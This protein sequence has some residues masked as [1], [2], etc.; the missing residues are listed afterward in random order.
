[1]PPS[2]S[3]HTADFKLSITKALADQLAERLWPL[4]PIPLTEDAVDDLDPRPGV[5]LLYHE[6]HRVYVGKAQRK[7]STRLRRHW[8]KVRGRENLRPDDVTF[9]GLYVD[10]DLDAAAPEKLLIRRYKAEGGSDG[11][12]WNLNGFGNNDPG[13][14]RD[15]SAVPVNHFDARYPAD[16]EWALDLPAGQRPLG[17]VL[18][19]AKQQ[20][21][22]NLRFEDARRSGGARTA[23]QTEVDVPPVS[24]T[25]S[26]LLE[27]A[28]TAL[29][30]SWQAT[31]LPGYV[32]LYGKHAEFPSARVWWRR[33]GDSARAIRRQMKL[34]PQ[35]EIAEERDDSDDKN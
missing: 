16:L 14:Q 31:A 33:A 3:R 25:T 28:I 32:I 13:K 20:L 18:E 27:L 19:E 29:P 22:Y 7:L 17:R 23:Y 35:R 24:I 26:Q 30:P 1:M 5:Y 4:C 21:P 10:E 11:V 34:A 15:L 12:P 2:E 6:G 8:R 9:V